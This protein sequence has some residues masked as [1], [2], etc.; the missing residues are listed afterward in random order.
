MLG[1]CININGTLRIKVTSVFADSAVAKILE[2]VEHASEKKGK[3]EKIHHQILQNL[4]PRRGCCGGDA[5]GCSAPVTGQPF[6][7]W[8]NRAL[9]FL[10]ISCPCALVISVPLSFFSGIGGASK[11]GILIKASTCLE[12]LS[13]TSAVVF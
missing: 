9:I 1:G 6:A 3:A 13:K 4:Y 7:S 8:V 10:V 5:C 2:M 12:A 11:R